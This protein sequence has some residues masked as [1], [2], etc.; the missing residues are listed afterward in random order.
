MSDNKTQTDTKKPKGYLTG[1]IQ[2]VVVIIFVIASF[3]VSSALKYNENQRVGEAAPDRILN[4]EV[5]DIDLQDYAISFPITGVIESRTNIDI[6]PQVSG[7][8]VS[9]SDS[10]FAGG[11]F[12]AGEVLFQ[13]N[14]L[15]FELEVQRLEAE[16]ARAQTALDLERAESS[17]A[18]KEW[19]QLRGKKKA[20]PDLVARKPQMAEAEANLKAAQALLENAKLDLQRTQFSLPFSGQVLS[21]NLS[22]GRYVAAGQTYGT[23][24]DKNGLEVKT[25]LNAKQLDWLQKGNPSSIPMVIDRDG[26]QIPYDG[27]L[28]RGASELNAMTRFASVSLGIHGPATGLLPGSFVSATIS[29]PVLRNVAV[30]PIQAYQKNQK[31]WIVSDDNIITSMTPDIIHMNDD[32]VVVT[33]ITAPITIVTSLLDGGMDGMTIARLDTGE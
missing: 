23:V 16:V 8:I 25:S 28:K 26:V 9:M 29:G 33:N 15:D 2:L 12:N 17:A 21:A 18:I 7:D 24:F 30:I 31:I 19:Q 22:V 5:Q 27:Y 32:E 6:V 10:F 3:A 4:V 1:I 14:P 11:E 20:V 13:I